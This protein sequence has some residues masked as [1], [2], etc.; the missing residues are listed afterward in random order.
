MFEKFVKKVDAKKLTKKELR[1]IV[2]GLTEAELEA[3]RRKGKIST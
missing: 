3:E 2:G 1:L